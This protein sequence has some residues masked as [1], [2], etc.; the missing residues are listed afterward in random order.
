[1]LGFKESLAHA[2]IVAL[3]SFQPSQLGKCLTRQG[4]GQCPR[5]PGGD[6]AMAVH[7]NGVRFS[8]GC[9]RWLPPL[10]TGDRAWA[11]CKLCNDQ[12]NVIPLH[13]GPGAPKLDSEEILELKLLA[14]QRRRK[15]VAR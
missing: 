5:H 14:A 8:C 13:G 6:G 2:D 7:E 3:M 1:M 9:C 11:A 4:T 15:A 10:H 12:S